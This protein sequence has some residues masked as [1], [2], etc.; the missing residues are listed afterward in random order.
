MVVVEVV[1]VGGQGVRRGLAEVLVL[2]V[3]GTGSG[4]SLEVVGQERVLG[5]H[6]RR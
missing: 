5:Q 4:Q 1:V 6:V 2:L 3:E